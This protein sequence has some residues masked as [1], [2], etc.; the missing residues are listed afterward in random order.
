MTRLCSAALPLALGLALAACGTAQ[1]NRSLYSVKQP[2]VQRANY[3]IDLRRN[4]N[5]L[6]EQEQQRL[7]GWFA[8][9]E[10]GYG[11]RIS[12]T[13]PAGGG[14]VASDVAQLAARYGLQLSPPSPA[15]LQ[16]VEPG[17]VRVTLA[18][19]TASVPGCPDWQESYSTHF[20]NET[21]NNF[22]C[23]TNANLAAM[24]ADPED[25]VRGASDTGSTQIMT[26]NKAI[27]AYRTQPTTAVDVT[28]DL[29]FLKGA[30][31]TSTTEDN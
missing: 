21:A 10:L 26:S 9:M 7:A 2:V 20:G 29:N 19:S 31:A 14:R 8:A 16:P 11:D 18:R 1:E 6:P 13:D 23:A 25:L 27:E 4:G 17:L 3:A 28:K 22:G 24:V 12:V 5:G 15:D 30:K